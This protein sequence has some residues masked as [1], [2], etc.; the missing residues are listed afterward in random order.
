[1]RTSQ[2]LLATLKEVPADAEIVSHQLMLRAG[3]IRKLAS[4]IYIWLPTGQRVLRKIEVIIREEMNNVG[5][6]EISMPIVQPANLWHNSGRWVN[7]GPELLRFTDRRTRPYILGPTHEEVITNLICNEV[8][9]YKQL[10]L[11]L[12]QIQTK[13]R[14]E[15]RPRFGVMRSREFIMKDSYSFHANQAS[16]QITYDAMYQAYST[17]FNRMGLNFRVVQADTGTIGGNVSHEF[18]VLTSSGEDQVVFSTHSNYA[19]NIEFAEALAG[20]PELSAPTEEM[21]LVETPDT[22]TI[23]DLVAQFDFPVNRV[24]KTLIVHAHKEAGYPLV[25]LMVRGDHQLNEVKATKLSQVATPLTFAS[26]DEIRFAIGAGHRFLGPIHLPMP[27][28]IDRSVAVM[29][30]FIA[31][32]NIEGKHYF[33]INWLR[34]LPLPEVADLRKVVEGDLSPDGYGTLLIKRGIEVGHL[35]Q[36]GTK[37]SAIMKAVVQD[38]KSCKHTLSMGCYGIGI[39]RVVAAVIEQNHD[40]HGILWPEVLAPFNVAILP[41][42]MHKSLQIKQV[43][44][45]IYGA[46]CTHGIDTLLDDRKESPG[47]MFADIELIGVPHTIIIS[48]H[49]LSTKEIEYKNR[50]SGKKYMIKID[51]IIDFLVGQITTS[52]S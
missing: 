37:Y 29:H 48:H 10:P 2:Y 33:G 42:N 15:I 44:E 16:L 21:H 19:A 41:I 20:S 3:M 26:E 11:N 6:I 17:I 23:T 5:A 31:G 25:A 35:F 27:L 32:A 39:T 18:Q 36:L 4:G 7:Y 8:S 43:A 22:Q 9:S 28:V 52:N 38:K 45:E 14:D 13:F 47:I 40:K 30:D 34:D 49:N 1:M 12:F 51:T 24:V 50:R 46:L